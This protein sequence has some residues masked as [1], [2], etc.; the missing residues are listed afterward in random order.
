MS[1][2]EGISMSP[3][4]TDA[5]ASAPDAEST[6]CRGETPGPAPDQHLPDNSLFVDVYA[7]LDVAI[8]L[9]EPIARGQDFRIASMNPAALD[10]LGLSAD[11]VFDRSLLECFPGAEAM[12]IMAALRRVLRDGRSES[13]P[14]L[15]YQDGGLNV[16]YRSDLRRLPGG[17]VMVVFADATADVTAERELAESKTRYELLTNSMADGIYDWNIAQN[18]IYFSPTWK[19]QLGYADDELPNSLEG[20]KDALHP[21][22][23]KEVMSDL[24]AFK[25]GTATTWEREFQLRHK[26]GRYVW[27]QSRGTPIRNPATGEVERIVGVHVDIDTR[28]REQLEIER[29]RRTLDSV[30]QAS[31]D[32]YFLLDGDGCID[33]FQA[34]S[35]AD[36]HIEPDTAIG[37]NLLDL[38][39]AEVCPRFKSAMHETRA[40]GNLVTATY[41]HTVGRNERFFEARIRHLEHNQFAVIVREITRQRRAE[42]GAEG[43]LRE[44][45]GLYNIH[46]VTQSAQD[47]GDLV[48]RL[49]PLIARSLYAVD[50]VQ[51]TLEIDTL[52]MQY[53]DNSLIGGGTTTPIFDGR[54]QRGTLLIRH[55][56]PTPHGQK[57]SFIDA[58]VLAIGLWLQRDTARRN[59]EIFKKLVSNT[60][61]QLAL[62]DREL[63]YVIVNEAYAARLGF[64]PEALVTHAATEI[65]APEG[66]KSD[67]MSKLR[68]ALAGTVV[69]FREWRRTPD[70]E[71]YMNILYS[72]YRQGEEVVGIVISVHD[73][74]DLHEAQAQLR[75]TARV[76]TDSDEAVMMTELDGTISDVNPAFT[77]IFGYSAQEAKGRSAD[78]ITA[79]PDNANFFD[80]ML[81]AL[82]DNH[83]WRGEVWT[84]RRSGEVF[85]TLMT[86][87]AVEDE[88]NGRITG[89]VALCSDITKIKENEERLELLANHDPLT[90]LANRTQLTRH[91]D[92][93]VSRAEPN[94]DPFAVMFIDLDRFKEVN[95]TLGHGAGDR[96]LC[97]VTTRLQH[98]V[99][100]SDLL[101][102]IGGDEFVAVLTG[103]ENGRDAS[104]IAEKIIEALTA[105]FILQGQPVQIS[106]SVGISRFPSDGA[107]T[108]LLLRKADTAMYA[109]KADGRST[110]QNFA[111]DM[112]EKGLLPEPGPPKLY[113]TRRLKPRRNP[114]SQ[115]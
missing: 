107:T 40:T 82:R 86:V 36:F 98:K 90:G 37:R 24:E 66:H 77:A 102:R 78:T 72:P 34:G 8:A 4:S 21:A 106:A 109:A 97:E 35:G 45:E 71:R 22:Q 10:I 54:K 9:L 43:R 14:P 33:D 50:N 69:Q 110:W 41:G 100:G 108:E 2:T 53:G 55:S 79:Q 73:I 81:E 93:R 89:Y 61:D 28:K 58:A 75:R 96:L 49:T 94:S 27:V 95:D 16:W 115:G 104:A 5:T 68:E 25:S 105:P 46:C 44:L 76:F 47:M 85:P 112:D 6:D 42:L 88:D 70:G 31:P 38:L 3:A 63:R 83:T 18:T 59:L 52:H 29:Q 20:W 99:R 74:T 60:Q 32:L 1:G 11:R 15:H 91:L 101:A 114:R 67:R 92:S 62:V 26:S 39:P 57:Q 12:G 103:L 113:I 84:R 111:A 48:R 19:A 80:E 56:A 87:S 65:P 13:V 64:T 23:Q 7:H 51:V 17:Q 30:F